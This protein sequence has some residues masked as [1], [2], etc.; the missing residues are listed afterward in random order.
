MHPDA[1]VA[2]PD[3]STTKV[4]LCLSVK[5][6]RAVKTSRSLT[7][8]PRGLGS[9]YRTRAGGAAP[10]P[11]ARRETHEAGSTKRRSTSDVR[12][13]GSLAADRQTRPA[14]AETR[15]ARG[16]SRARSRSRVVWRTA[17]V[18]ADSTQFLVYRLGR[19]GTRRRFFSPGSAGRTTLGEHDQRQP[20]AP[21]SR[22]ELSDGY[23]FDG[24]LLH[25]QLGAGCACTDLLADAVYASARLL[26]VCPRLCARR[27]LYARSGGAR[28]SATNLADRPQQTE[29][30]GAVRR[31][32]AR[33]WRRRL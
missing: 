3:S 29:R 10:P 13:T 11:L 4:H 12:A 27:W 16:R 31:D 33:L 2:S 23:G 15:C 6:G 25:V 17:S 24:R 18:G 9:R 8:D 20:R 30:S 28:W 32:R 19:A 5:R 14:P 21:D 7:A 22:S 26:D 1:G